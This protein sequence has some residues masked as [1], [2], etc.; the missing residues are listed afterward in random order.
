MK[1]LFR[2]LPAEIRFIVLVYFA[3][4]VAF[5]LLR[6]ILILVNYKLAKEVPFNTLLEAKLM[7]FRFDTVIS[8][9]FLILPLVLFFFFSFFKKRFRTIELFIFWFLFLI[10]SIGIFICCADIPWFL[11]DHTRISVAVVHWTNTPGMMLRFIFEDSNNYPFLL[12]FALLVFLFYK[13]LKTIRQRTLDKPSTKQPTF[14]ITLLYIFF[15]ALT[16]LGIRGRVAVKSPIRWGTAF[17][18]QYNFANQIGLNPVYTFMRSWLDSRSAANKGVNYLSESIALEHVKS[19]YN[20]TSSSELYS[21]VARKVTATGQPKK[22]N[23]VLVL[24]EG[25]SAKSMTRFGNENHLTPV[26]D[27]LFNLGIS[28]TR[29]YSDGNHTF[30]G[31]YSSLFGFPSLPMKHSMKSL[32][33]QQPYGGL[34]RTLLNNGYQTIFFTTH[35]EQFDNMAGF[36]IPNGFQ[37]LVS[38]KDYPAEKIISTLGAPDH[39]QFEEVIKRLSLLHQN[40]K[41]FFS[42]IMT[43]SNHGP[44]IMPESIPFKAHSP[45]MRTAMIEYSD[46]AIGNFLSE[47]AKRLWFDSTIFIFTSDHGNLVHGF[48]HHLAYHHVPMIIYAPQIFPSPQILETLGGQPDIYPTILSLLNISYINNS[49]GVDLFSEQRKFLPFTYDEELCCT[50]GKKLF[51]LSREKEQLYQITAGGKALESVTAPATSDSLKTHAQSVMQAVQWMIQNK[52]MY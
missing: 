8:G 12:A 16:L 10:Y 45:D 50:D 26:L 7:G 49:F 2:R 3:G 22:Y 31:I 52:K 36:L 37:R 48:P 47:S 17:F 41:P 21:P 32:E 23:I 51:V 28:F 19:F 9:Y 5:S 33:N 15:I 35:D 27:S 44:Y 14:N 1:K 20:I 18:S 40:S 25:I 11:H 24:M 34:P 43:A 30:N 29:F 4:I 6:F 42:A 39:I 13:L 38:Q 46:W